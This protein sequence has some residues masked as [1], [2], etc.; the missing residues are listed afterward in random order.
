[1]VG[2]GLR[3]PTPLTA[4]VCLFMRLKGQMIRP[5][6]GQFACSLPPSGVFVF[7]RSKILKQVST[8]STRANRFMLQLDV[9]DGSNQ[10]IS[11]RLTAECP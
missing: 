5:L 7:L 9:T 11:L 8:V 10:I 6:M 3:S 1:M 4:A 2:K